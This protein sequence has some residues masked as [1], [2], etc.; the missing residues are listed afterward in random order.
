MEGSMGGVTQVQG[1]GDVVGSPSLA[2]L[3][4][5]PLALGRLFSSS[6][7]ISSW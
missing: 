1:S 5:A 6:I 7:S 2:R 3:A 4:R